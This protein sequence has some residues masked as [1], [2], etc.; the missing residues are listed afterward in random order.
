MPDLQQDVVDLTRRLLAFDTIN[1]PGQEIQSMEFCASWLRNIGFECTLHRHSATRGSLIATRGTGEGRSLCL[2][3]HLDT[4]PLGDA[5]W[6][7]SPFNGQVEGDRLFGRGSSDMKGAVAAFMLA[8]R[9]TPS[10]KG[11]VTILL[12]AGEET[13]CDGARWLAEAGL[14]PEAGAMI[15]GESSD[16]RP[17]SGHK[18][19]YWLKLMASGRTAHGATPE[20]GVNAILKAAPLLA[21]LAD[22]TLDVRH[23]VM[24]SATWNL[25]TIHGGLN[26]NSVPD[27][28]ELTLDLR[29]VEGI[30]HPE[31]RRR[32]EELAGVEFNVEVL[33]DLPAVWSDPG[34]VWFAKAIQ[35]ISR[36]TGITYDPGVASYFT[37]ASIL[38]PRMNDLPVMILGPGS[39]DQPHR[40]DEHVLIS[41]LV[42]A[43]EIY[44]AL[45]REW[46]YRM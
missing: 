25:S 46:D 44:S 6:R 13:G 36:V 14:L 18:G 1:P 15:V 7:W 26:I 43:V 45:L 4:V 31:I 23:P 32:V 11:G 30:D 21:R 37:D 35:T 19:A 24:G 16:N 5:P 29:S 39:L 42:E 33:L 2:S 3:G 34:Q 28:C 9:E 22:F 12:T 10:I 41:R 20:L 40:T 8:C 38:K 27:C 17:L